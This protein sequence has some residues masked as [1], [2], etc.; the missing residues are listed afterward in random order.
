MPPLSFYMPLYIYGSQN[1]SGLYKK[2]SVHLDLLLCSVEVYFKY[3]IYGYL[4]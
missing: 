1:F 3:L 4:L 2:E